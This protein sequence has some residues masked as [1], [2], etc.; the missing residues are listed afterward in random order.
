MNRNFLYKNFFWAIAIFLI[1]AFVFSALYAEQ[2]KPAV[3]T[4]DHLVSKI[5][6][7]EI[8]KIAVNGNNLEIELKNGEKAVSKKETEAGLSETLKNYGVEPAKLAAVAFEI[9]E[10]SGFRFWASI[11]LPALL[12]LLIIGVFFWLM[13]R[14]AKTGMG[15]AFTFGKANV[16][17]FTH[18]KQRIAFKDVAGLKEAKEELMEIVDFLKNPKK[19]LEIGATIPRGVLL[20]GSPGCGKTYIARAVAGESNVPFFHISGSEFVEMFVGVGSSRVRDLFATAKKAAPCIVFIDEIDAIGRER[21]A[22]IG[23]GH[24]EREQTL[25]QILVEMDG[26]ERDTK[27]IVLAA[28][29][30]PDV[31]DPALLRPGRFDRRIILDLPDIN[32]REEILKIHSR[33]KTFT[34]DVNL[35]KAAER[36]PGFS[37]ADLANLMNEAAILAARKIRNKSNSRT[38]W[39]PLKKSFWDRNAAAAFC[40]KRKRYYRLS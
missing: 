8:S 27:V 33:N 18:F 37:G 10:E 6:S 28:T 24:D 20:L 35:R 3:L 38:F 23:G 11:L 17:L 2:K 36:T 31:L 15:Q 40:P 30:R 29:N 22:G 26:F 32:D 7:E 25:N 13:F 19:Y 34:P 1:L 14:Q 21:G 39:I 12:P 4:I 9:K 16:K 5:N